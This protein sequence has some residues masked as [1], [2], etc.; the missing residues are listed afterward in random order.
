MIKMISLVL[1]LTVNSFAS[2]A[3]ICGDIFIRIDKG[4]L[5]QKA[6]NRYLV[7]TKQASPRYI[8][9]FQITNGRDTLYNVSTSDTLASSQILRFNL[10]NSE[11]EKS[12]NV[13]ATFNTDEVLKC[14]TNNSDINESSYDYHITHPDIWKATNFDDAIKS[15]YHTST[16]I[17]L[18]NYNYLS[19]NISEFPT[20]NPIRLNITSKKNLE[21]IMILAGGK[22]FVVMAIIKIPDNHNMAEITDVHNNFQSPTIS[23][24][25]SKEVTIVYRMKNGKVYRQDIPSSNQISIETDTE[26]TPSY[27]IRLLG[28]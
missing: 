15:L 26:Y 5:L 19:S 9:H 17:I 2:K 22:K 13:S 20:G 12:V 10:L 16:P 24:P 6:N 11:Q 14:S 27:N 7:A 25:S 18:N 23:Y 3:T 28:E 21:S 8:T 1:I 4:V